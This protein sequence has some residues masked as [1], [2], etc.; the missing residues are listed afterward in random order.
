MF[1]MVLDLR[2]IKDWESG[3]IPFFYVY[4]WIVTEILYF[5]KKVVN[6]GEYLFYFVCYVIFAFV[7]NNHS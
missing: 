7:K 2:L 4:A 5:I 3:K 1:F 6:K